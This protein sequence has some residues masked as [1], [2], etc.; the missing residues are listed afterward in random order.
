MKINFKSSKF[1]KA[2]STKFNTEYRIQIK[3]WNN[4]HNTKVYNH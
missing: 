3:T 2:V 4:R 1:N